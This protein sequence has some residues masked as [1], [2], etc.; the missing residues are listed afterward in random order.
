MKQIRSG[1]TAI[2]A[3]WLACC[4]LAGCGD[5]R[6][7]K[8]APDL[9]RQTL[10]K[11]LDSWKEGDEPEALQSGRPKITVQDIDWN[12]GVQLTD[13]EIL[14]DGEVTGASLV[15]Q[16]KL[17]L[18]DKSDK[19]SSKTVTYYVTTAPGFTVF[20]DSFQR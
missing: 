17:S 4:L 15:A 12:A 7:Y 16:V 2:F 18:R 6:A 8:V 19:E 5:P 3:G 14:G 20:R 9:A 11:V 10:T 13:Y 1:L